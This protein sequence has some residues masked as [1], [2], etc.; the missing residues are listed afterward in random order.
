[1][2]ARPVLPS[3]EIISKEINSDTGFRI[4]NNIKDDKE[5]FLTV[6]KKMNNKYFII[7]DQ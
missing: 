4:S 3:M 7:W 5:Y 2:I 6:Q 1:M